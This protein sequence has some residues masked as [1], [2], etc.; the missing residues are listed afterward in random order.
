MKRSKYKIAK[1]KAW[2]AFSLYIRLKY[3]DRNGM[4]KCVTCNKIKYYKSRGKGEEREDGMQAGH[5]IDGRNNTVLF[6]EDLVFPQDYHCNVKLKG[7][8][9]PYT[10]FMMN[11]GWSKEGIEDLYNLKFQTRVYKIPELIEIKER[12]TRKVDEL[13][14]KLKELNETNQNTQNN[15]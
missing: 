2:A 12:Y 14:K 6:D 7:N 4:V 8:K 5:F 1:D 9:V 11:R 3:A 15:S 10:I 13:L